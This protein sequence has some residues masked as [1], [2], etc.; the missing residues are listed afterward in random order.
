MGIGVD[1][2]LAETSDGRIG[3]FR[4]EDDVFLGLRRSTLMYLR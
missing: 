4:D 3:A 1:D 2:V